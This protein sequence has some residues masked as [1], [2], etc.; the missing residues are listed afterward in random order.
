MRYFNRLINSTILVGIATL[1]LMVIIGV[2][3]TI[4][5][6]LVGMIFTSR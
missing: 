5:G 2:V 3:D 4:F 6:R 1:I